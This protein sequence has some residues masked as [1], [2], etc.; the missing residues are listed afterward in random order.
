MCGERETLRNEAGE[1]GKD[2]ASLLR[3]VRVMSVG[4]PGVGCDESGL[5]FRANVM[6]WWVWRSV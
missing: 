1:V 4:R 5:C 3:S 2:L 6:D